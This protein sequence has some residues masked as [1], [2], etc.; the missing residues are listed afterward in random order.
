M[1]RVFHE[2]D[3]PFTYFSRF[4]EKIKAAKNPEDVKRLINLSEKHHQK[5]VVADS[6]QVKQIITNILK[7]IPEKV[8]CPPN[9]RPGLSCRRYCQVKLL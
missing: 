7:N 4:I 2:L 1:F 8:A 6:H 5:I 3:A 9:L